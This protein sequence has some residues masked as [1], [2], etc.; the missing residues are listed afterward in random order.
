MVQTA[1]I[2]VPGLKVA[3]PLKADALPRGLVP[4]DGPAGEPII[5][6]RIEGAPTTIVARINGKNYRKMLKT[7]AEH[8]ADS[9][10]IVLQGNLRPGE[11]A[12]HVDPGIR[13]VPGQR[14]GTRRGGATTSPTSP[15]QRSVTR[16]KH[17]RCVVPIIGLSSAGGTW[18]VPSETCHLGFVGGVV[19]CGPVICG[20]L[21][22]SY[23][24][25]LR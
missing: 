8:G 11:H 13:R 25:R 18:G 2:T 16:A 1:Q 21:Q 6:L 9:V 14:Q 19:N 22:V 23:Q 10:V 15:G 4:P 20:V 24:C 17:R 12:R 5:E 3:V 7:V